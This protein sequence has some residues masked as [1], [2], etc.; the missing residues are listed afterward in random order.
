[1]WPEAPVYTFVYDAQGMGPEFRRADI[2]TSNWQRLP[3]AT[4]YYKSLLPAFDRA[5]RHFDL[6]DY[7]LVIS[8]ASG[9]A[10]SVRTGPRTLH[11]C[12][13]HTP[14][15]YLWRD[16]DSYIADLHYPAPVKRMIRRIRPRLRA[17]DLR[18]A[19]GVDEYVANSAFVAGRIERH[20]HRRAKVIHP[21]VHI[22][23]FAPAQRRGDYF[24]VASRLRPHKR[25]DL[26]I[27]A[28][29]EL[30]LPLKVMG[31]GSERD[32]LERMAGPTVEFVGRVSG[33]ERTRLFGQAKAFLNPQEEDF[34]L[35]AVEALA[36]GTPVIAYGKGGAAEIIDHGRTG[37]L[38][39]SRPPH[40]WS[41]PFGPS[42]TTGS[43][44]QRSGV[45][46]RRSPMPP[47]SGGSG[48]SSMIRTGFINRPEIER[49]AT[50][51]GREGML[52]ATAASERRRIP[53]SV[54]YSERE[55][56]ARVV[57]TLVSLG[58]DRDA[59]VP[60]AP[61]ET[62]DV[63]SLDVV[64]LAE[65]LHAEMGIEVEARDFVD[66]QTYGDAMRVILGR[67]A[68]S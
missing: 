50:P 66:V 32:R 49:I 23:Q 43:T 52:R 28:A 39:P 5:F 22:N 33:A 3:A 10:K 7:E 27:A 1:M 21:P 58:V 56:E 18:G 20:Y 60:E 57:D 12:Y 2:R 8:S 36:S 25:V 53:M 37:L 30:R 4:R 42:P 46:R 67:A 9:F 41:R 16:S 44:R 45:A 15:R 65:L 61:L 54:R 64:E 11:V 19:R 31:S 55:I 59:I 35:T 17:A 51:D 47:L 14:T 48:A 13:C 29:T 63:D 26:A 68:V 38:S 62:L 40:R 6:S 34:G 24:L